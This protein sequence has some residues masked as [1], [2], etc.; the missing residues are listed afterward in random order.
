[1]QVPMNLTQNIQGGAPALYS[2]GQVATM[3]DTV[4]GATAKLAQAQSKAGQEFNAIRD[5]F[6]LARDDAVFKKAHADFAKEANEIKFKYLALESE[7]AVQT[8]GTNPDTNQPISILDQQKNDIEAIRQQYLGTLE[9]S[10]QIEA[11]DI[12][13]GATKETISNRM[14]VHYISENSKFLKNSAIAD[15]ATQTNE[16]GENYKDFFDLNGEYNASL[17]AALQLQS[18]ED[19]RIG[20]SPDSPIRRNN[21]LQVW[22]GVQS[23]ALDTMIAEGD[24]K[25]AM[26]FLDHNYNTL[27]KM[28][29]ATFKTYNQT[30][31]KGY[32]KQVGEKQATNIFNY[33]GNPNS[34]DPLSK[35]NFT[36]LLSS[37]HAADD[38]RN[39]P[40]TN[41]LN[42]L[43]GQNPDLSDTEAS[44]YWFNASKESKFFNEETGVMKI[45]PEHQTMQLFAIQTL[46]VEKA[47]SIFTKA[48]TLSG[49]DASNEDIMKNVVKL[50]KEAQ[51]KKFFGNGE[52]VDLVN[53]DIDTILKYIDYDYANKVIAGGKDG[54]FNDR[55][56]ESGMPKRTDMLELLNDVIID[57]EKLEYAKTEFKKVYDDQ[58]SINE[59]EY[60]N[61]KEE[62][63]A[64]A[65]ARE[66]GYAD[67]NEGDFAK[68]TREDQQTA[69]NGHPEESDTDTYAKLI[70][71]PTETLP[72]NLSKYRGLLSKSDYRKFLT[73]G[74]TLNQGGETKVLE[75]TMDTQLFKDILSKNGFEDIVFGKKKNDKDKAKKYNSILTAVENR[76]DYAQ[77]IQNKKLTRDEKAT[78]LYN[79]ISDEVNIDNRNILYDPK[80]KLY[81]GVDKDKL[82]DT[83]VNVKEVVDGVIKTSRIYGNEIP[84][85]VLM[86]IQ[87]SLYERGKPMSQLEIAKEWVK[88]GRP[89]TLKQADK[90]INATNIY[91]LMAG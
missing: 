70:S 47:D 80:G 89:L 2:G 75:A 82:D 83:Y 3:K 23:A 13:S 71:N 63:F 61:L 25:T 53:K 78:L 54:L 17:T 62:I 10:R 66:G 55:N 16:A 15:I 51:E 40:T 57:D 41:G 85:K 74:Q 84:T 33:R 21:M 46:G 76:I 30:V 81:S 68:L 67:V 9:N 34:D 5:E 8:V 43:D 72:E 28:S 48:K 22:N 52:H 86:A 12:K 49:K 87:G 50:F 59:G 19:N 56:D 58:E 39:A 31:R 18:K 26:T 36:F 79:T 77:R 7:G 65:F 29:P 45:I 4:S 1:M 6:Q 91:G 20:L 64:T 90:N 27:N 24:F 44:E 88:F 14:G 35:I 69:K 32:L 11:F 38:G 60:K 73:S 42:A 37:N